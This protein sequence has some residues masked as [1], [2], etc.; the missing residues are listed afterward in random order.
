MTL[1]FWL[2]SAP[3]EHQPTTLTDLA[4]LQLLMAEDSPGPLPWLSLCGHFV[5]S[6]GNCATQELSAQE[7]QDA[8]QHTLM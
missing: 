7:S 5:L 4:S 8:E 1:F 2:G 3:R 6:E